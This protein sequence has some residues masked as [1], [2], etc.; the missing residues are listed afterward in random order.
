LKIAAIETFPVD[1]PTRPEF[2]IVSSLG[3]HRT[4]R[5]VLVAIR[6]SDGLIG[7]GEATVMPIWSGETQAGAIAAIREVLTPVLI[8]RD[9][10]ELP[11]LCDAMDR[12][13]VGNPFTK[14]A[15]EMALWDVRGKVAGQPVCQLLGGPLQAP[16]IPLKFSIGAF[17]PARAAAV[18]E[19]MAQRGFRAVKVKVGLELKEDLAR[20]SAV[21]SAVGP[22]FRVAVDANGGWTEEAATAALPELERLRVNAIEQPLQRR[23]FRGSAQLRK[24]TRIP[25]MLDE[26]IFTLDDALEAIYTE[27]CDLISIYP[28]KNGGI[29]RSLEIAHAAHAAGLQCVIGSNLEWEIGSA[30]MLHLAVAIPN[31]A[32]A[33]DHDIIGTIYHERRTASPPIGITNGKALLPAGIGLGVELDHAAVTCG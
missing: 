6:T 28:G 12:A 1:I 20:V 14:A 32:G 26:A 29:G 19:T 23:D 10:R 25:I 3:T 27:A 5:Y 15:I 18:A 22:D 11:A 24:R 2:T 33:V 30:A 9:P 16:E 21:R 4:S 13:L 7:Y 8:G 31:L 17:T